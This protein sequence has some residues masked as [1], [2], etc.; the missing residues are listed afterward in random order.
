MPTVHRPRYYYNNWSAYDELSDV[1]E[2]TEELA[3]AQLDQVQRL[4]RFGVVIE[5]YLMDCF[6]FAPDGGYRT[7]RK[8]HWPDGPDR[9]LDACRGAGLTPGLWL[10][11]NNLVTCKFVD[12]PAWR[13]SVDPQSG[14]A[15]LASGGFLADFIEV[16]EHWVERGVAL[17]KFDFANFDAATEAMRSS[18]LPSEIREAN[19]L[20]F[21]TAIRSIRVRHPEVVL[22]AYN[23]FE[24]WRPLGGRVRGWQGQTDLPLYRAI[25]PAW[26]DCFDAIYCGDPRPSDVPMLNFWRSKDLYSDQT[27]RYW[28]HS[29]IPLERIDDS[30]F[31]IGKT[32]TCYGRGAQAWL[33]ML[34]LSLARGN[35]YNS[36]YGDLSLL[37]DA[38][39][40]TLAKCQALFT[41]FL[42]SGRTELIGGQP[43]KCEPYGSQLTLGD[44]ALTC[45]VNPTKAP[46]QL[47]VVGAGTLLFADE[48]Y[49]V[50]LDEGYVSV[51]PEQACLLGHGR[52]HDESWVLGRQPDFPIRLD[53]LI[54]SGSGQ[55]SVVLSTEMPD[56]GGIAVLARQADGHGFAHRSTGGQGP[57]AKRLPDILR[58]EVEPPA[59]LVRPDDKVVWSGLSTI[60]AELPA[61]SL[62]PGTPVV[63]TVFAD[64]RVPGL[65]LEAELHRVR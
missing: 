32:G 20:A 15:C 9:W 4:R 38:D 41:P 18:M 65:R 29:G 39:A 62:A 6:W 22:L 24:E 44:G 55:G 12:Y 10:G 16:M 60:A 37:S 45:W 27:L 31:M 3:M 54:G 52:F 64:E 49:E 42:A 13:D 53:G 59:V 56:R 25:D 36:L 43:G 50:H 11:T 51:G 7:W 58:V 46:A 2:L 19:V 61:G 63:L 33:G 30:A 1:V 28:A 8:P 40:A 17:F 35:L 26:L 47:P 34:V 23:G 14:A 57:G 48:G 5:G 21:R